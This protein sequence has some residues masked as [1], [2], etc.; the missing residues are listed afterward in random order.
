MA[1]RVARKTQSIYYPVIWVV[2]G[3]SFATTV[4][5]I[6]VNKLRLPINLPTI[7]TLLLAFMIL[8][9]LIVINKYNFFTWKAA[10]GERGPFFKCFNHGF[11]GFF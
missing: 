5:E 10:S 4:L 2:L 6:Y 8:I 9:C 11:C 3:Y 1:Y 7:S